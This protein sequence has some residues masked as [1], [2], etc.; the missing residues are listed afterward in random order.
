MGVTGNTEF[1]LLADVVSLFL[2]PFNDYSASMMSQIIVQ[3]FSQSSDHFGNSNLGQLPHVLRR[4]SH[5]QLL[6]VVEEQRDIIEQ[7]RSE[8]PGTLRTVASGLRFCLLLVAH[9]A[10]HCHGVAYGVNA[11][12]TALDISPGTNSHEKTALP[13]EDRCQRRPMVSSSRRLRARPSIVRLFM[14]R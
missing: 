5:D 8:R 14:P 12:S 3:A 1:S 2:S 11:C 7:L 13:F 10:T 9:C 6:A 4:L